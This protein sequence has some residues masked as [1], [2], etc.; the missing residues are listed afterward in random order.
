MGTMMYS[1]HHDTSPICKIINIPEI[2][3]NVYVNNALYLCWY[4]ILSFF[5]F[6]KST[7]M[8][9]LLKKPEYFLYITLLIN[10]LI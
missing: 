2:S 5:L 8:L 7:W 10:I 3:I 4:Y 6:I 9:V 1:P